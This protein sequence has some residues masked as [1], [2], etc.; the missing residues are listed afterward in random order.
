MKSTVPPVAARTLIVP[1]ASVASGTTALFARVR[2][3]EKL[4]ALASGS[5]AASPRSSVRLPGFA[6]FVTARLTE[7]ATAAAGI[8]H[9]DAATLNVRVANGCRDGPPSGP[10]G[11]RVSRTRHGGTV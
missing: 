10:V 11:F 1:D 2:F 4:I 9:A 3:A 5:C 6:G 8:P 7:M